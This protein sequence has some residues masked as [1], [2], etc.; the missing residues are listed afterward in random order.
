MHKISSSNTGSIAIYKPETGK[1]ALDVRLKQETV[2]LSLDQMSHLF[3]RD[4]SVISRHIKNVFTEKELDKKAVVAKFATTAADGKTY[5]VD[6]YNLDVII[7]VGYRVKSRNG[8][9][10]RIW[11]TR[12][13]RNHIIKGYTLNRKRISQLQKKQLSEFANTVSLIK[14]TIETRQLSTKEEGGLLKVITEYANSW[15][16]LQQYDKGRIADIEKTAKVKYKLEY[17]EAQNAIAELKNNLLAQ[18]EASDLFG[19]ERHKGLNQIINGLYQTF[20]GK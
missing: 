13:L 10:F 5:Q 7:S 17:S 6:Y 11:A 2:W 15:I 18:K 3:G 12:I 8:V 16:L 4:K 14:K 20:G 9:R 1:E 19:L